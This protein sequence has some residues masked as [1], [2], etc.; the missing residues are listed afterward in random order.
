MSDTVISLSGISKESWKENWDE[1]ID[2]APTRPVFHRVS[3][4]PRLSL[5][6]ILIS[7]LSTLLLAFMGFVIVSLPSP[8]E[9][10]RLFQASAAP[11]QTVQYTFQLPL[12]LLIGAFLGPFM[13]TAALLLF[14]GVGL[15]AFPIFTNGGGIGY[16][17]QPG[18]GYLLGML[19]MGYLIGKSFHKCFQKDDSFSRSLKILILSIAAVLLVHTIGVIYM[20]GLA[21]IGQIAWSALPGWILRLSVESLPYDTLA[22]FVFL[23]LVRQIRLGLWLVLY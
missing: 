14:L 3:Y 4:P 8:L 23:C 22:T 13:G 6:G 15:F 18:F 17:L 16:V 1:E 11:L 9:V 19:V 2:A 12:A 20:T 5:N 21:L 7:L 10:G